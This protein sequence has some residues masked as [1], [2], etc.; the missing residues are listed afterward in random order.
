MQRLKTE[1]YICRL[2]FRFTHPVDPDWRQHLSTLFTMPQSEDTTSLK[3]LG[4]F[5]ELVRALK[6]ALGSSGLTCDD[7]DL[8]LLMDLMKNYAS[9]E[10]EW[11]AFAFANPSMAYTRNLVDEGNGKSNLV[12]PVI[13]KDASLFLIRMDLVGPRLDTRK[14]K[15]HPQS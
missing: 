12:R 9:D 10:K 7:V 3:G 2:L 15:P 11:G 5:D 6:D 14:G 1:D 4:K 8:D 13:M